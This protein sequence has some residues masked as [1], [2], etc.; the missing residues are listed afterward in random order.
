M[1]HRSQGAW[2][3][4]LSVALE[5][6]RDTV[7]CWSR[8]L[9]AYRNKENWR[10]HFYLAIRRHLLLHSKWA[11]RHPIGWWEG[12][13]LHT[14]K[15]YV[16]S[17]VEEDNKTLAPAKVESTKALIDARADRREDQLINFHNSNPTEPQLK[18]EHRLW[19][20]IRVMFG[21]TSWAVP[22]ACTASTF[23]RVIKLILKMYFLINIWI[24]IPSLIVMRDHIDSYVCD[25]SIR[26]ISYDF[27]RMPNR[28][29]TISYEIAGMRFHRNVKKYAM[30]S[31]YVAIWFGF[32]PA[33]AGEYCRSRSP[34]GR[35]LARELNPVLL[36]N[37]NL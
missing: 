24:S 25:S 5:T 20:F 15:D 22:I 1:I 10:R 27:I 36:I 30:K 19:I 2:S 8:P 35:R 29:R 4:V 7:A 14:R 3:L 33:V 16:S 11:A 32:D 13:T 9:A 12:Q 6:N 23:S 17:K 26:M 28:I 21:D 31:A 18:P 34:P 37:N